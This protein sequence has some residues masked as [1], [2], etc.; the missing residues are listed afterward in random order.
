M[1]QE[2]N[3]F[4]IDDDEIT[5]WFDSEDETSTAA[6]SEEISLEKKY[7]ESQLRVVLI[8]HGKPKHT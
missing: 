8:K 4:E 3:L 7:S 2:K 6:I 1:T 5:E